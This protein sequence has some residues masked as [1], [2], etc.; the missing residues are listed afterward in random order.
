MVSGIV[1][2]NSLDIAYVFRLL[3]QGHQRNEFGVPY[4]PSDDDRAIDTD[5]E[6]TD[7]SI[8]SG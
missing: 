8:G 1:R 2:I 5:T 3:V 6:D 4:E 7:S